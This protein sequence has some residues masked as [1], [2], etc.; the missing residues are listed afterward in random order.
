MRGMKMMGGYD[1]T[2]ERGPRGILFMGI[3]PTHIP[4]IIIIVYNLL[5]VVECSQSQSLNS[6]KRVGVR[7]HIP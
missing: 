2:R 6:C 5:F 1:S 3:N 4:E 7:S